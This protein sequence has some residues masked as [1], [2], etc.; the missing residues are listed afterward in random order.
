MKSEY[1]AELE[2]LAKQNENQQNDIM[3]TST[4][5]TLQN[6]G[7]N[8]QVEAYPQDLLAAYNDLQEMERAE[9]Y[10]HMELERK[11]GRANKKR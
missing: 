3:R 7:H 2:K 10:D 6:F 11:Y 8:M 9:L 1:K 5:S 4:M